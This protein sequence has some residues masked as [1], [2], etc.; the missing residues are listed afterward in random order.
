MSLGKKIRGGFAALLSASLIVSGA[1]LV[2]PAASAVEATPVVTPAVVAASEAGLEVKIDFTNV[3]IPEDRAGVY[4]ALVETGTTAAVGRGAFVDAALIAD[5]AGSGTYVA[6]KTGLDRSKTYQALVW[7]AHGAITTESIVARAD[8][9][10]SPES[11]DL[12]FPPALPPVSDPADPETLP[13]G[14]LEEEVGSE[15]EGDPLPPVDVPGVPAVEVFLADGVTPAGE[16]ELFAGD[17][18]VVKG[19]GFDVESNLSTRAPITVGDPAGNYIVFGN[20]AETWRPSVAGTSSADRRVA[21]QRWALSDA[22]YANINSRYLSAVSA[23]RVVMNTD[24][25]FEFAIELADIPSNVAAPTGGSYGVFTYVAGGGAND[26]AQ[27]LEVRLNYQGERPA[28]VVE[29]EDEENPSTGGLTWALKDSWNSYLKFG[30]R[31]TTTVSNGAT[32]GA[33]G[34][35]G[36]VQVEGGDYDPETGLG[37]IRYQ[38]AVRYISESHGF[39]ILMQDP[40]VTFS[41]NGATLSAETSKSETSGTASASRIALATLTSPNSILEEDGSLRWT[42]VQGVFGSIS[43]PVSWAE[44][45]GQAI[46]PVSFSFGAAESP[47]EGET[48]GGVENPGATPIKP[49]PIPQPA[50]APAPSATSQSAGSLTWGISTSFADYVTGNVAKGTITTSGVGGGRGG[51]VFPQASGSS[52]NSQTQTGSIAFSGVVTFT[53]HNGALSRT[54][55]NPVITVTSTSSATLSVA[56]QPFGSLNL[57]AASKSVGANGE[58][59]WS[60]V[61][62]SGGFGYGSY[63]LAADPLTFTAG[64]ASSASFGS[65]RVTAPANIQRTAATAPPAT[66]GVRVITPANELVAGGEIEFEASGFQPNERG[67]LVVMYSEPTVLDTNAGADANGVVRWIGTLPDDLTGEHTITLQGSINV[68]QV[69]SIAA[70]E[71]VKKVALSNGEVEETQIAEVRAAGLADSDDAGWVVWVGALALLVV[72][73]GLAALVVAQRRRAEGASQ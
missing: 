37:T 7:Y 10:V 60:G 15:G 70:A 27:E 55:S 72:A 71:Q 42:A 57:A 30:A 20:F 18:I 31:A 13:G 61:P 69:I 1:L 36:Y 64:A 3:T 58:V 9:A 14:P 63:D 12:V 34:Q 47:T 32:L 29:E 4:V 24:G 45:A 66:T 44:Y 40:W 43:Q 68:G 26:P 73:G 41:A 49:T 56:G 17:E 38:G 33:D 2:A 54:V 19:S 39:N 5:G 53:G 67:I 65:T 51:Y 46:A 23:Q 21:V 25:T 62:V 6:A 59:T 16:S 52:W 11:W 50:P 28:E 48:P 22:S 8:I 35:I